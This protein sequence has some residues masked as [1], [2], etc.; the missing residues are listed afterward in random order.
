MILLGGEDVGKTSLF[1]RY[2]YH[3]PKTNDATLVE[4]SSSS[5]AYVF[6]RAT[7]TDDGIRQFNMWDISYK[8][9]FIQNIREYYDRVESACVVFDVSNRAS[10]EEAK[11]WA[12]EMKD[13]AK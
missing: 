10:F 11:E 5:A 7:E 9:G 3:A 13:I 8:E 6:S 2:M 4:R 1:L 12:L